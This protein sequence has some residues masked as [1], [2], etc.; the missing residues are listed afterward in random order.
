MFVNSPLH[1]LS[2]YIHHLLVIHVVPLESQGSQ[3]Q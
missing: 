3:Y 2:F 1:L